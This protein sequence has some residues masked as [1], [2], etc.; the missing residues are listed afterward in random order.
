MDDAPHAVQGEACPMCHQ[1]TLTLTEARREIPYFGM[2]YIFSMDCSSC[3]YHLADIEPENA[4][5]PAKYTLE[6]SG[7]D[8]LTIRVIKSSKATVKIPHIV[9][10]TPGPAS[11]GYI[12]NVEGIINRIEHQIRK[13]Y[14]DAE[15]KEEKKKAKNILKKIQRVRFGQDRL[16]LIIEDPSGAS[17]ILSEKAVKGKIP[18]G[19]DE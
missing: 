19:A 18:K 12:T 11:N 6:V 4:G 7:E 2:V 8:D 5:E 3:N 14:E 9:T 13:S 10:V 16:K 17:A 1:K 15:D